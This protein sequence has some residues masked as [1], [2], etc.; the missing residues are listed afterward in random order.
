[1][2]ANGK[3]IIIVAG[4]LLALIGYREAAYFGF[5]PR[6]DALKTLVP[7]K[8]ELAKTG[9]LSSSN[10]AA[11][12]L[13]SDSAVPDDGQTIRAEVWA[14]NAQMG[15]LYANGGPT[16]TKG[17]LMAKQGVRE[18][19]KRQDDGNQMQADQIAF[20]SSYCVNGQDPGTGV[21]FV[22]VMGDGG[23]QYV[24]PVNEK[25]KS[26]GC[27]V[28]IVG[29]AGYSRGEDALMGP[30]EWIANPQSARG[31]LISGVCRDGD[32]NIAMRW[33]NANG[34]PNNPEDT[35]ID[36]QALNWKCADTYIQAAQDWVSQA[37]VERP[38]K[39]KPRGEKVHLPVSAVVTWF[40]GDEIAFHGRPGLVKV[41]STKDAI[42]QMPAVIIGNSKWDADHA[43]QVKAMLA[44]IGA[45]GDQVRSNPAAL[46]K[47]GDIS[48]KIYG[49]KNG[50]YWAGY[51]SG[52]RSSDVVGNTMELGGSKASN[53]A[54]QMQLFGLTGGPNLFALTYNTFGNIVHQQ[55]PNLLKEV[56]LVDSITNT[57]YLRMAMQ[58]SSQSDR[59]TQEVVSY[60]SGSISNVKGKRDYHIQ[61]RSGSAEIL[62]ESF[63]ELDSVFADIATSNLQA[64]IHGY[65]DNT[66]TEEGNMLLSQQR[67]QSVK[68]Y[69]SS[70]GTN[71]PMRVVPH[72]QDD[73]VDTNETATGR[74]HNRRVTIVLGS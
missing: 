5:V 10:V 62:P 30:Q 61:F 49:E 43:N 65:T 71:A 29:S 18:T 19:I 20:A 44:A 35:V 28:E 36:P 34:I 46:Q 74:A 39:S 3:R 55:Y 47:A 24:A 45:G 38:L 54:D 15:W 63:A 40:P 67:A 1:M 42:F 13:P 22:A 52:V 72:G 57:T 48:A 56:P 60:S 11:T 59:G 26:L 41:L 23:A 66:G 9:E 4:A 8:V 16:T 64:V 14:W 31:K 53:L 2:Q 58:S 6:P 7:L 17:S 25:L 21:H 50:K 70:K 69:L 32:W 51:Y 73:P 27:H 37:S 33:A 12:P 68:S